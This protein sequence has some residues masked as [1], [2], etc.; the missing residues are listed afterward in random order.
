ML[1]P[2]PPSAS[3]RPDETRNRI[4]EVFLGPLSLTHLSPKEDGAFD[5]GS[6]LRPAE[7]DLVDSTGRFLFCRAEDVRAAL[8]EDGCYFLL[9]KRKNRE[10]VSYTRGY[11]RRKKERQACVIVIVVP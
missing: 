9:L 6:K 2:V 1:R 3:L 11:R 10:V 5:D 8:A 7:E 4:A